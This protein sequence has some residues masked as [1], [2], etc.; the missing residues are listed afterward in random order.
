MFHHV[1]LMKFTPAA[2]RAFHDRVEEYSEQLRR[3]TPRLE[4]YVYRPNAASR[5]DGLTHVILATFSTGADHDAY[6]VSPLHQ[7]MK[8]YMSPFIER[9]VVADLDDAQP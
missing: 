5:S 3:T 8:A 7:E 2:D 6:Q 4:R 1:V 9:I